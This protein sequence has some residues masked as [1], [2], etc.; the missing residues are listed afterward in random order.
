[1]GKTTVELYAAACIALKRPLWGCEVV[2]PG[3]TLIV[4]AEDPSDLL[5]ARL[6]EIL[7]AMNLTAEERRI[8][9]ESIAVWDISGEMIR[10]AQLNSSGNIELTDL[11]DSIVAAYKNDNLVQV[12]FDPVISF[13][14]GERVINDGEQAIVTACRRIIRG[15][16]CCVRLIH[17]TGK[18]NARNGAIDQYASRGGTA[19]PDGCRMVSILSSV[20]DTTQTPPDGFALAPGDSGFVMARAKLSY[21]PPQ[22]NIWIRRRGFTFEYWLEEHRSADEVIA[23][24]AAKVEAFVKDEL[25]HG[26]KYTGRALESVNT[27]KLPRQRLRAALTLLDTSGRIFE[28]DLPADERRGARKT[29][30]CSAAYCAKADGAIEPENP[31]APADE[32]LIAPPTSIAPP[33][34][35]TGNGAIDA[36]PLSSDFLIAPEIDGAIAAQWRNSENTQKVQHLVDEQ[37]TSSM[38]EE[39]VGVSE[40]ES[41]AV[42]VNPEPDRP[43]ASGKP[44]GAIAAQWRNKPTCNACVWF[45]PS[46]HYPHRGSC[47]NKKCALRKMGDIIAAQDE[48]SC[49]YFAA[50]HEAV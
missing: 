50:Q 40:Q 5:A 26:R 11:A 39:Q 20:K 48:R 1:M 19:L 47:E 30:L 9:R 45:K 41:A 38:E 14:P 18:A 31:Y 7:S 46:I 42:S 33:Y 43:S 2:N 17:H 44:T 28:R 35:N 12:I 25:L 13:G 10:L 16:N 3:K 27:L 32:N 21:A 37:S 6:R 23:S 34:R 22:P 8:A 49:Q 24:D 15:L 4:T 36:I 29:Y